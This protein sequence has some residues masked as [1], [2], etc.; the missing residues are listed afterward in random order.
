MSDDTQK[1][2]RRTPVNFGG[3]YWSDHPAIIEQAWKVLRGETR[4]PRGRSR[5]SRSV[6]YVVDVIFEDEIL[7]GR[8]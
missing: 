7:G 8:Q 1:T 5:L 3:P 4:P 6:R 2:R